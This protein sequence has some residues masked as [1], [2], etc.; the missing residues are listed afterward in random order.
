M[1]RLPLNATCSRAIVRCCSFALDQCHSDVRNDAILHSPQSRK[2]CTDERRSLYI[3]LVDQWLLA[4]VAMASRM[5]PRSHN[6][7]RRQQLASAPLSLRFLRR[8]PDP[9]RVNGHDAVR[10]SGSE[11]RN[12]LT[13]LYRVQNHLEELVAQRLR[14]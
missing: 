2:Q 7:P 6:H 11:C 12:D 3:D 8:Y 5:G 4:K 13:N 9:S 10:S 1:F 14:M